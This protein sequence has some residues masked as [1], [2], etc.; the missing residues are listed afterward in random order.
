MGCQTVIGS[1]WQQEAAFG[2]LVAACCLAIN[3]G[4]G[5]LSFHPQTNSRF[6]M[7]QRGDRGRVMSTKGFG[8]MRN[9]WSGVYGLSSGA[10][11]GPA[12]EL[13]LQEWA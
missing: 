7:V 10:R 8:G 12:E 13:C 11:T 5:T 4:A 2:L 6:S 3:A 1:H 9:N